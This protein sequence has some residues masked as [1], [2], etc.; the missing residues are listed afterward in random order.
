MNL[1]IAWMIGVMLS[2]T[3]AILTISG[4]RDVVLFEKEVDW[5]NIRGP[6]PYVAAGYSLGGQLH[7]HSVIPD[8][9][10]GCYTLFTDT[11][12]SIPAQRACGVLSVPEGIWAGSIWIEQSGSPS[13]MGGLV[14]Y[15]YNFSQ[16]I[17]PQSDSTYASPLKVEYTVGC[18]PKPVQRGSNVTCSVSAYQSGATTSLP[19][20]IKE[21][22]AT[23]VLGFKPALN[24]AVNDSIVPGGTYSWSGIAVDSTTVTFKVGSI[25]G[26]TMLSTSFGV[27]GR[28]WTNFTIQKTT[29]FD[30]PVAIVPESTWIKWAEMTPSLSDPYGTG[31][32]TG[33]NKGLYFHSMQPHFIATI[34]YHPGLAIGSVWR[35]MQ[36]GVSG[37]CS[38][39][40][41]SEFLDSLRRH[42]GETNQTPSHV[43]LWMAMFNSSGQTASLRLER[44][45]HTSS[46]QL[47]IRTSALMDSVKGALQ[48][49]G[50]GWSNLDMADIPSLLLGIQSRNTC[51]FAF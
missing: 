32:T 48:E 35:G 40:R 45:N 34:K 42:E 5:N 27:T 28:G 36:T 8:P 19:I 49:G 51:T 23:T 37:N 6:R 31:V 41:V 26:D 18:S 17:Y 15:T 22:S 21:R 39:N 38:N 12:Y 4:C 20:V 50:G 11:E 33:P 9:I 43:S 7:V 25:A 13:T 14:I 3:V 2:V 47:M 44:A 24:E 30:L 1:K 10:G 16:G 46:G 29:S